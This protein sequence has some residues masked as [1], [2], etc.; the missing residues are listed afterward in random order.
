MSFVRASSLLLLGACMVKAQKPP[1]DVE[2]DPNAISNNDDQGKPGGQI[3]GDEGE[4]L[5]IPQ[6]APDV[7]TT[8]D[9]RPKPSTTGKVRTCDPPLTSAKPLVRHK[10]YTKTDPVKLGAGVIDGKV[11]PTTIWVNGTLKPP[12]TTAPQTNGNFGPD[13]SDLSYLLGWDSAT[14]VDL[15]SIHVGE[16]NPLELWV[17]GMTPTAR[18]MTYTSAT[19]SVQQPYVQTSETRAADAPT[20]STAK[21]VKSLS[22]VKFVGVSLVVTAASDCALGALAD[23]LGRRPIVREGFNNES[24]T[25][26]DPTKR[27][28]IQ[29]LLVRDGTEMALAILTSRRDAKME[30]L[31]K[32]TTCSPTDLGACEKVLDDLTAEAD[33]FMETSGTSTYETLTSGTD[34][35]WAFT[36]FV[37]GDVKS[38]K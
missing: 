24:G 15:F 8:P 3:T 27:K 22:A 4:Q 12:A 10:I 1:L 2:E 26:F 35:T 16:K 32:N 28:D 20:T 6:P 14:T 25:L 34:P 33:A 5:D 11:S 37:P 17:E 36:T 29:D 23:L 38:V 18:R 19:N 31:V 9:A 13:L 30:D 21:Y 7:G